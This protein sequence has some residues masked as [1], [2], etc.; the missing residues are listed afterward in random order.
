MGVGVSAGARMRA[1]ERGRMRVRVRVIYRYKNRHT[2]LNRY[3]IIEW[4]LLLRC[5]IGEGRV[6]WV[7][8]GEI[9]SQVSK[10][11]RGGG[12]WG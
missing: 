2:L 8:G 3:V 4:S 5:L 6:G 12:G 11:G 10:Q 7:G 1:S 9:M